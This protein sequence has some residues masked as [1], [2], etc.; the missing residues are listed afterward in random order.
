MLRLTL[1]LV[2]CATSASAEESVVATRAIP[3]ATV[4][5]AEDMALVAAA[6][7]G[8]LRRLEDAVGQQT[9]RAIYAGRPILE[10]DVATPAMIG[11]NSLVRLVF[12]RG[13]LEIV[14]EGRALEKGHQGDVVKVMSLSSKSILHGTVIADGTV[15]MDGGSCALC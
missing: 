10:R 12:R 4:L 15:S 6:I 14:A 8:A 9:R 1:M 11:R 13:D 5:R 7:P 3:A 2:A